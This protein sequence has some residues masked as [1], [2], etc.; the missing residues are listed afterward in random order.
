MYQLRQ[1]NST[2]YP[3]TFI[4]LSSIDH[5]TA[6][7]GITP[8]V[9]LSKNGGSFNTASGSVAEISG[10]WYKLNGAAADR[11]TLGEL[12]VRCSGIGSDYFESKYTVVPFDPFD[13]VRLGLTSL[14]NA[15]A[16]QSNGLP[17]NDIV[18][19][20]SVNDASPSTT[21]FTGS[22]GLSASNDFY[23]NIVLAFASG[24]CRGIGRRVTTY[25]GATK[26]FTFA[27][28]FPTAP[29]SG[30]PFILLGLIE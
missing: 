9:T 11:D 3:I 5:F 24:N 27:S 12:I 28:G 17:I 8:A 23:K 1:Q 22:V 4:M 14:P 20:G 29:A 18:V 30:D 6:S 7:T 21:A 19:Y 2:G 10:G 15:I 25:T 26:V 13:G 16:G